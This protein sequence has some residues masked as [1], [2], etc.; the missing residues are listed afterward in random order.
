MS[1]SIIPDAIAFS[2]ALLLVLICV[3]VIIRACIHWRLFDQ[4]GRLK[5]HSHPIPRLGGVAL[6][7]ALTAGTIFAARSASAN[8]LFFLAALVLIWLA[9]LA[10]D[11]RELAPQIRLAAQAAGGIL[12]YFGGWRVSHIGSGY[13]AP[14]WDCLC[15]ALAV[16]LFVNAFNFL[17]GADG[18]AAGVAGIIA[19]AYVIIPGVALS[20]L[21]YAVACSLLGAC[22]GF[23]LFNFPPAKLFMG[24]SGSTVLGFSVAFLALDFFRASSAAA[25]G[26]PWLFPILIAALPLLD[27][28]FAV[29]RR[30]R[31]GNSPLHG[32]RGH[33]YDLLLAAGWPARRV[34]LTCYFLTALL[35][36]AGWLAT[37]ADFKSRIILLIAC[38]AGLLAAALRLGSFRPDAPEQSNYRAHQ[39]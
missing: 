24:D 34:A 17:D 32:D 31:N 1:A 13:F 27:A 19:L 20:P 23:L 29:A 9:G 39:T 4:P 22:A 11:I 10:D 16:I 15:V 28:L 3:P 18:L 36:L 35:G 2:A 25:R 6:A 33:F 37:E 5:I 12:L 8:Y 38:L 7:L 26:T 30:L 14:V 21:G